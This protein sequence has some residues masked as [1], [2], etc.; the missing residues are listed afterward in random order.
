MIE[1]YTLPKMQQIWSEENKFDNWLKIEVA[2]CESLAELDEIPKEAVAEIKANATFTVDRIKEIEKETRH[3]ILAFL[4]AVAESLG[5]ESK[6]IHLGLTSSDIKDTARSLQLKEAAEIILE[7][8]E[9]VTEAIGKKAIK[10]KNQVMIGRTHGIHA[11]PVTF[12]FKLANWYAEMQRNIKRF[13]EA[14]EDISYGK[15]SGAVGTFANISPEVEA[16]TCQLLN[17]KPAP[18][19]SQILQRDR[20]AEYISTLAIIAGSL[21]RFATEIRNLQRT[22]ILEVE[23][24]FKKGQKGSSAM[25]HKKNPITCE[26]I[27]GL[28][29]VVRSNNVAAL[30]NQPLWHERDLT[31]SSVERII[32]PDSSILI[33]YM[34]TKFKDV[35]E[36]LSVLEGNMLR[37]LEKTNGLIFSQKAMLRLVD[38]GLLRDDAYEL[39]QRNALKA[40]QDDRPFKDYLLAD[41]D[42]LKYLS[43]EEIGRIFDYDYHLRNID[44]VFTRLGLE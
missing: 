10:Y 32:F 3:D 40:W 16:K 20:H 42:I 14:K 17:L 43:K 19:S 29:R 44:Q 36:K 23:E 9:E 18:I 34:L 6:Y 22:D 31:H 25:P 11:E 37:N 8:L 4:T 24:A 1:R 33:D 15:I 21:D 39:V 41:E 13:K 7:D 26:R 12:G 27:S 35:V 38:K 2:V 5:E 30:E 28:A